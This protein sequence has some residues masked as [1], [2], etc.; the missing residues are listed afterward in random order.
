[1]ATPVPQPR[2]GSRDMRSNI[3][4]QDDLVD[5]FSRS[6]WSKGGVYQAQGR[7]LALE[8]S[9]DLTEMH[10]SVRGTERKPYLVDISLSYR[11]GELDDMAS[12]CTCFIG[13][14]CKHV[15][16]TLLEVLHG[17]GTLTDAAPASKQGTLPGFA[18]PEP[19]PVLAPELNDWLE[20]IGSSIRGNDYPADVRQR[21]LYRVQPHAREDRMPHLAVSLLS[22]KLRKDGTLSDHVS[23]SNP[24][25]NMDR[26]PAFYR[27]AD[28]EIVSGLSRIYQPYGHDDLYL[29]G[30][31]GLLRQIVD[32]GR[33]YWRDHRSSP[34]QWG[35][36]REGRI[37]WRQASKAGM[38]SSLVVDGAAALGA[39]PPVYVDE[40]SGTVGTV[41]TGLPPRL[42]HR[43]LSAPLIPRAQVA[44]VA[45]RL[46]QKLPAVH[47][48]VLPAQPVAATPI[49]EDPTPVLRLKLAQP[50]VS[51][52]YYYT[53]DK[54]KPMPVA[55]LSFRYGPVEIE[56]SERATKVEVFYAG[57][58]FAV[59]RRRAREKEALGRL[60][61]LGFVAAISAHPFLDARHRHD[62]T[63]PEPYDWLDFLKLDAGDLRAQGFEIHVD[64]EFPYR[65]AESASAFDAEFESSGIDWFELGVGIEIDGER[66]DLTSILAALVSTPG[67]TP[68]QI[69][70]L[71]E[72]GDHFYLPLAD[73]RHLSLAADRF[74]PLVLAL[75][76]LNLSGVFAGES[77]KIRLSRAD[78]VPLL[79]LEG[80]DFAFKGADNLRRMAGLLR[81]Q[82]LAD[83]TLPQAFKAEL[84]PYQARGVAWLDLLRESG[85]GGVLADDMG[86]GKT[87]QTLALLA[88]EN[89]RGNLTSP[90]L[91]VAPT[92]LMSNWL[93]EAQKFAPELKVLV[94][95]GAGRKQTFA[96]IAEHDVVLTT[97]PLIARDHEV[98][99]SREWHIA[100]L[101]EAQTIKNPNAAT[102]RWLRD[103]KAKHRF[104]L[105]GTPMENHLGELWSIMSFANPGFLGEKAA[106][107]RQWRTPIEKRAD[108]S[109]AAALAQRVK[110]FLL[111]RTKA[112]VATELPPKTEI[113]ERIILEGSQRDLY[114]SVRLS[115][116]AKVRAAIRERGLGKSHIVVLEA[117]LRMRQACCHPAL[118]KLDD[119][120]ERPAAKLDRLM[121][122]ADELLS[123]G[124]KIIIFSQFTSMI[125]LMRVKF[126]AANVRY[127]LLTGETKDR[128]RAIDDFQNGV[129]DVFLISLKAGGVGLNLTAADTV[130]V[131]DPWWNPAVEEQAIDRA[132]RIGQ[133]KSVFV[134]RL[135]AA[136]TIEEKM[137][138]LKARKRALADSLFDRD[139]GIGSA[140][141]EEDVKALFDV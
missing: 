9:D 134:Y 137:D 96:A 46:G 7:V 11:D 103:I 42:A 15:A 26:A 135:V 29:I 118:L 121:E 124:R 95:H 119:G 80:R 25:T 76:T 23:R 87:I 64:D 92:S 40:T 14:S 74:L 79:G 78:V 106:F 16:A 54:L 39:E 105:T 48:G 5:F 38:A 109:R 99:L 122:M 68:D 22:V 101:D 126:D 108:K 115:M 1:M 113:V 73:G 131:F 13:S 141:T 32:T 3:L 18:R 56:L 98:L 117:L 107:A 100:V 69:R 2:T 110:P 85:L 63:F 65:L 20:K 61:D 4:R 102:T 10:A 31:A 71:A 133:D 128:K 138:E 75:H 50:E 27:D 139:G 43:M 67:F 21:L 123:E 52:Y 114:D 57:K 94:L 136:E 89:E 6:A 60:S 77:G 129:S 62:L 72:S 104:C 37:E 97:Y 8:V 45:R 12:D 111:R 125:A 30:S 41:E 132:H 66:R 84:R 59:S 19:P 82:G 51:G 120:V 33:A 127:S 34:L 55:H 93:N 88:L 116:S 83:I 53:H 49:D 17:K 91:V 35:G 70:S 58:V 36:I 47:H 24:G 90:A 130:I 112:E 86:L 28:L 140:L 44:E 81:T